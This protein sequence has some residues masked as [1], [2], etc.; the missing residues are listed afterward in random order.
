[1]SLKFSVSQPEDAPDA[2][3]TATMPGSPVAVTPYWNT[4][5]NQVALFIVMVED[6]SA[7]F[8]LGL[9]IVHMIVKKHNGTLD[10]LSPPPGFAHGFEAVIHLQPCEAEGASGHLA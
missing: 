1:M 9:A 5:V 3:G 7:G 10:L 8:G 2:A 6:G 4:A